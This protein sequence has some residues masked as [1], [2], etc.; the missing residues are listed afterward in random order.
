M[1][2]TMIELLHIAAGVVGTAICASLSAWALPHAHDTIWQ[3]ALV[4][5]LVVL[6]MGVR[7]LRAAWRADRAIEGVPVER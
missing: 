3:V 2:R 5:M 7:P 6:F 1:R 4:A